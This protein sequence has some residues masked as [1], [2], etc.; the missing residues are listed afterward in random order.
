MLVCELADH[1]VHLPPVWVGWVWTRAGL[2][3]PRGLE[4]VCGSQGTM[5]YS[6]ESGPARDRC[7]PVR[8][9]L[10]CAAGGGKALIL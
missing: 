1:S 3:C 8:L 10:S 5:C 9:K 2:G 7:S 6:Q 4:C